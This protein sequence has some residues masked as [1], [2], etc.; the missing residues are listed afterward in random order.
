MIG[1][2]LETHAFEFIC[3]AQKQALTMQVKKSREL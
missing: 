1:Q 2:I 3:G